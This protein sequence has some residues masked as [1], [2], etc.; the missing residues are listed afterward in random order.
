MARDLDP[1]PLSP[2]IMHGAPRVPE[3][4][5][6]ADATG[7]RQ[8]VV[9]NPRHVCPAELIDQ[10]GIRN[11]CLGDRVSETNSCDQRWFVHAEPV[12]AQTRSRVA[13]TS[14]PR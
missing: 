7:A 8:E 3:P 9:Y 4:D 13:T 11:L 5:P 12:C 1:V 10:D 6:V 14:S 2:T